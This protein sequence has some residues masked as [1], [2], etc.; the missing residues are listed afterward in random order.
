MLD[1]MEDVRKREEGRKRGSA[2]GV[3][4]VDRKGS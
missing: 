2:G 4:V 1:E 3:Q